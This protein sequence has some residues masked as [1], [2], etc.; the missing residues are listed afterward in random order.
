MIE[1]FLNSVG[2]LGFIISDSQKRIEPI[3]DVR[4]R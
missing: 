2:P 4:L 3:L 1:T